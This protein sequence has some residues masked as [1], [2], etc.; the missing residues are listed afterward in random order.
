MGVTCR[1]NEG[2]I[3]DKD[4]DE[5]W[6]IRKLTNVAHRRQLMVSGNMRNSNKKLNIRIK[7][8]SWK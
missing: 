3:A 2:R 7:I 6:K 8:S 4:A 5:A 1:M